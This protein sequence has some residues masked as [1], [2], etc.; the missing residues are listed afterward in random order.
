MYVSSSSKIEFL[1]LERQEQ[2]KCIQNEEAGYS[3]NGLRRFNAG[4]YDSQSLSFSF[5]PLQIAVGPMSCYCSD[6]HSLNGKHVLAK[7]E[8]EQPRPTQLKY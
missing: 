7:F 1:C 3:V 5:S 6:G 2:D 8:F 4:M